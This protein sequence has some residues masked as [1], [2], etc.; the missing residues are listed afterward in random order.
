MA[1]PVVRLGGITFGTPDGDGD[2]FV[3]GD[4]AGWTGIPVE[5]VTV[6]KPT[7]DGA[8]I[9]YGRQRARTLIISGTAIAETDGDV[10][11]VRDKLES[12]VSGMVAANGTLEVDEPGETVSLT[13]RATAE[14]RIRGLGD[15][16]I[17]FDIS[18]L[19]ANPAKSV[20]P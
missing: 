12:A 19:A 2:L 13:V 10:W 20:V 18:L 5:L 3:V 17:E 14:P 1:T 8:V 15:I 16:A 6:D 11:R 4:I 7:A 9:V